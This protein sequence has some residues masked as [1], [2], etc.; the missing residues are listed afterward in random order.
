MR[1][2][3]QLLKLQRYECTKQILDTE[4]KRQLIDIELNV[5]N[6]NLMQEVILKRNQAGPYVPDQDTRVQ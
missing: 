1:K 6:I 5:L 3:I 4:Q 2:R